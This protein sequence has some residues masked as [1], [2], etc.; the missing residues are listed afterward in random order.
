MESDMRARHRLLVP[1]VLAATILAPACWAATGTEA[2]KLF[3]RDA[4]QT[5]EAPEVI[6]AATKLFAQ[7]N[8]D[9]T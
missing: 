8:P 5:L 2:L 1:V 4:D 7:I 6:D 9:T 3:N